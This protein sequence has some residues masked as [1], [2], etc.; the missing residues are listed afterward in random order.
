M[1]LRSSWT[2]SDAAVATESMLLD[3]WRLRR[4]WGWWLV[5][6]LLLVVVFLATRSSN[7]EAKSSLV[8]GESSFSL[9]VS[10]S[11]SVNDCVI[12]FSSGGSKFFADAST[13]SLKPLRW[14]RCLES[15][16]KLE[17]SEENGI[18]ISCFYRLLLV[19]KIIHFRK[20]QLLNGITSYINW[21]FLSS[22]LLRIYVWILIDS[23]LFSRGKR[24]QIWKI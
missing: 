13:V 22:C 11:C 14:N 7:L 21:N 8:L 12:D 2:A 17:S 20:N 19:S 24:P 18:W 5:E 4:R 1:L 15:Y 23:T 10:F 9:V 6:L 16:Y 3:S